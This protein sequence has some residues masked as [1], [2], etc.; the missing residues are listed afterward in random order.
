MITVYSVILNY[1]VFGKLLF[2]DLKQVVFIYVLY[3]KLFI[4]VVSISV[5]I[6]QYIVPSRA[7][8]KRI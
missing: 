3:D 5:V 8:I 2:N 7:V 1:T 6:D 4:C